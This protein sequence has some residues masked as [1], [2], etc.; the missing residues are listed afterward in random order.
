MVHLTHPEIALVTVA[1]VAI[2]S[3]A[4]AATTAELM[5]WRWRRATHARGAAL[6]RQSTT[7][8][9]L[10]V[11]LAKTETE[12]DSARHDAAYWEGSARR[13]EAEVMKILEG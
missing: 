12:R 7:I 13:F 9:A 5:T 8:R 10:E 6:E 11:K 1:G 3:V 2:F 4:L